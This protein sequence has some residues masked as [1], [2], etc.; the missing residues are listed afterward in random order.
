MYDGS[1]YEAALIGISSA[2]KI[3]VGECQVG[4]EPKLTV[5]RQG[6]QPMRAQ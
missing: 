6:L 3:R 2:P 5:C 1:T 4:D